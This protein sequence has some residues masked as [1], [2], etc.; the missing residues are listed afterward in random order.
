MANS[1]WDK[2]AFNPENPFGRKATH[3]GG[4]NIA[5]SKMRREAIKAVKNGTANA[6]QVKLVHDTDRVIAEAISKMEEK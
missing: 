4:D 6:D 3:V 2:G 1:G 5:F